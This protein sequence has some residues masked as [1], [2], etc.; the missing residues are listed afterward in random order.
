MMADFCPQ[1]AEISPSFL[2]LLW[3][4]FF[5]TAMRQAFLKSMGVDPTPFSIIC[6]NEPITLYNL[7][8]GS[9]RDYSILPMPPCLWTSLGSSISG[10]E[11]H[12]PALLWGPKSINFL[13]GKHPQQTAF[14]SI[15]S[16]TLSLSQMQILFISLY[17]L[18]L[19]TLIHL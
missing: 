15:L 7:R 4:D 13:V 12:Q 11:K 6:H 18:S 19:S 5:A 14:P 17:I 10:P 1:R 2:E 8:K 16:L 3:S 9:S